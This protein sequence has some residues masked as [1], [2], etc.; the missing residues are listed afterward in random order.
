[1]ITRRYETLVM[2]CT[3]SRVRP[4]KS[5]QLSTTIKSLIMQN[6]KFTFDEY[7]S[8]INEF[9][10]EGETYINVSIPCDLYDEVGHAIMTYGMPTGSYTTKEH[11]TSIAIRIDNLIPVYRKQSIRLCNGKEV[12]VDILYHRGEVSDA[13]FQLV[14]NA[15][16]SGKYLKKC[17]RRVRRD[18]GE[19]WIYTEYNGLGDE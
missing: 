13:A 9:F 5:G 17:G 1:M 11:F 8:L 15:L 19:E 10:V 7:Q 18:N 4:E 16:K 6:H 2:V 3:A 12:G 14:K